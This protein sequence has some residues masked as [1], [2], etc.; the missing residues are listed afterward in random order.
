MN[1]IHDQMD[2]ELGNKSD[3]TSGNSPLPITIKYKISYIY[4]NPY[5]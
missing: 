2:S 5:F 1:K 3:Q 4:K